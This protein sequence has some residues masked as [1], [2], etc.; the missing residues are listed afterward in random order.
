MRVNLPV[1]QN[2][3]DYPDNELLMSTTDQQGRMTHC[4]AAF[5]R[6]SGFSMEELMGQP[7]NLVRHPDMPP[8]AFKDLWA[9]IGNGR[10]WRGLVKNRRKNGDHYWVRAHVTP[11]MVSGKPQGYM[12]VREKP[13][14]EEVRAAEAL[15]ERVRAER[16][17][18]R[19]TFRLHAGYVR[20]LGWRDWFGRLQRTSFTQ[21][22]SAQMLVLLVVALAPQWLGWTEGPM[23]WAQSALVALAVGWIVWRFHR[24]ITSGLAD[25]MQVSSEIAG[26]NLLGHVE[27]PNGRH[28]MARLMEN[29]GQIQ[30]N[31]R[32]VVGDARSEISSF[33]VISAEIAQGAMDLSARTESQASSLQETAAAME[34]LSSTASHS[35]EGAQQVL[36]ESEHSADLARKGGQAME[37]VGAVVQS[38]EQ[39]SRKMGQIIST[40]EGIAFQTNILA[41]NA[42][43]EAARAGEQGRGFAVVAGEVRALAQRSATA[44][45]EIRALIGES[46]TQIGHGAQQMQAAGQT[47]EQLVQSVGHVSQL[48][49]QM[50]TAAREQ[51]LGI[52]QV[53][54]A[55]TD[56][57]RVTQQNAALV[58]ESAASARTMSGN[59][60]V[61]GRTLDVFRLP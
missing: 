21:R 15:Y 19:Q 54:E 50:G 23:V 37:Q 33:G 3:Y 24:R 32:A 45:G 49:H 44:A 58:E 9:T 14:R 4:N 34:E 17:A 20:P 5:A 8:E 55:V 46:S 51:T 61:L 39:S 35:A 53:N 40:I 1:T 16:E 56:L 25:A 10:S 13:T 18:G 26:C 27:R 2:E 57:D 11:I 30:I 38:I 42:A 31:L 41:L 28:P 7:H 60:G 52:S 12:S 29:L 36:T 48:M 59:A 47:I 22:L 6:V 43:V